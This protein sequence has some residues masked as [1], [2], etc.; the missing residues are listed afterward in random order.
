MRIISFSSVI[1]LFSFS[2]IAAPIRVSPPFSLIPALPL[3]NSLQKDKNK[4]A[5]AFFDFYLRFRLEPLKELSVAPHDSIYKYVPSLASYIPSSEKNNYSFAQQNNYTHILIPQFEINK[6]KTITFYIDIVSVQARTSIASLEKEISFEQIPHS[7]DSLLMDLFSVINCPLTDQSKRF[8]QISIAGSNF[9]SIKQLGEIL[10]SQSRPNPPEITKL[11]NEYEKC[12]LKDPTLL[13]AHYPCSEAMMKAGQF[14]KSAKY[15]KELLDL[16]PLHTD[17]Y[18]LLSESYRKSGKINEAYGVVSKFEQMELKTVPYLCERARV[19]E[20]LNQNTSAFKSYYQILQINPEHSEALLFCARYYNNDAK[21]SSGLPYAEAL[22]KADSTNG[23]G[24]FERGRCLL[25]MGRTD[26]AYNALRKASI[27][28]PNDAVLS[29][30]AGDALTKLNKHTDA[31]IWY[32]RALKI[33]QNDLNL[34]LKTSKSIENAG[35]PQEALVLLKKYSSVFGNSPVFNKNWGLMEFSNNNFQAAIDPLEFY[36][37][38][39]QNDYDVLFALGKSYEKTDQPDRALTCLQKAADLT[40]DKTDCNLAIVRVYILKKDAVSAQKLLKSIISRSQVKTA[41]SLL[42]DSYQISGKGKEALNNYLKERE[43][44]GNDLSLQEKIAHL[45]FTMGAFAQSSL[46][47]KRLL[48]I[49]PEHP[50]ARY[51]IALIMLKNGDLDHAEDLLKEASKFGKGK[52]DLIYSV[53]N[54]FYSYKKY[55]KAIEF[56]EKAI[57]QDSKYEEAIEKCA[58]SEINLG[59]ES[60]GAEYYIQLFSINNSKYAHLLAKAGDLYSKNNLSGK[61]IAAY[62]LFLS[63]GFND[64]HVN[65]NYASLEYELKNYPLVCTLLKDVTPNTTNDKKI[66]LLLADSRC[67]TGDY[68]GSLSLLEYILSSEKQNST[69]VK[70]SAVAYEKT[71][72][73]T[74]SIDMY[75]QFLKLQPKDKEF[76]SYSFHLGQLYESQNMPEKAIDRYEQTRKL[77]PEDLRNHERL[78]ILYMNKSFW[79]QAQDV[80]E[81]ALQSPEAKPQFFKMIAQ[82]YSSRENHNKAIPMYRTYLEKSPK[83]ITAWK[84]LGKIYFSLNQYTDAISAFTNALLITPNDFE[85]NLLLGKSYVE[86][87]NYKKAIVPLGHAKKVKPNDLTIIELSTRCYRNLNETSTLTSLLKEWITLDPKRYDIKVELGS[88]YLDEHNIDK[89]LSYLLDAVAFLPSE[90]RPH[91]LL[92]QVYELQGNDSLRLIHLNKAAKNGISSWELNFQYARYF[93]SKNNFSEAEKFLNEVLKQKPEHAQSHFEIAFIMNEKKN[94]SKALAEV[95]EAIK[96]DKSNPL[97]YAFMSYLY[98]LN[99]M[100]INSQETIDSTLK[101][102]SN[103]PNVFYWLSQ[104]FRL[105]NQRESALKN[106]NKALQLNPDFAKGYEVLGDIY[107]ESFRFKDASK[108]YFLSWEK[109]GYNPVRAL[110][111]GNALSYN[112]QYDEAKGFY[113]AIINH[114]DPSGEA[115]YRAIYT[116][117]KLG[118]LKNAQKLQKRFKK[119]D[120]PWI[121][122]AQG[123]IYETENNSE[124][125][126]TAYTIALRI[127]PQNPLVYSGFGRIYSQRNQIDSSIANFYRS[128]A[129]SLDMQNY[130]DL[131]TAFQVKGDLDSALLYYGLVD[132]RYPQ[133]PWIQMYIAS[134][135]AQTKDHKA[136]IAIL[137]RGIGFHPNDP[138]LHFRLGQELE[139]A[140]TFEEAISEYHL[141]LKTGDG[142]PIEALRNIGT[143]YFQKLVNDKK[144]KEYYK[145]YVKAGG[146]KNDIADA[147]RKLEKI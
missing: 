6:N 132:K 63:K 39:T 143:I 93:L 49:S 23:Y 16:T 58:L 68:K 117:C 34:I 130:I 129:D 15:L 119:D 136:A 87:G 95:N 65:S 47:Y 127:A 33:N 44:H 101:S 14:E 3:D 106:I 20:I 81:A 141:S 77:F 80:L 103:D 126:L 70:L 118:D 12:I 84:E 31:V 110:K 78:A 22:I 67:Q 96:Y 48:R 4:W 46:E 124:S 41:Y 43:L 83:D 99:N 94:S 145:K 56:F 122:L 79:K 28:N 42:G 18:I 146:N 75:E 73:L 139:Y 116:Y 88:V 114:N 60:A 57:A 2:L 53:G 11:A 51:Y 113:E 120:A 107:L 13:I 7:I 24:H 5:V 26:A 131:A 76:S 19:F 69:A 35:N 90:P 138:M 125:A 82:T 144:A 98:C 52:P 9:K 85:S 89:A 61:A 27:L 72:N 97:Y 36:K 71:N 55:K 115:I 8:F 135:H 25:A 45:Q 111:L 109:G 100:K 37:K 30:Y 102:G 112:M 21:Y 140:G 134:V 137:R 108:N 54:E 91:L 64:P 104:A 86:S 1:L 142:Q 92:A 133:H 121:Q 38:T 74:K 59:N 66:L 29:E 40:N 147:M 10:Y 62:M 17:L 50:E 123:I 105:N 32:K 128:L